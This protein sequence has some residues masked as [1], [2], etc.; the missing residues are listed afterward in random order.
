MV[1]DRLWLVDNGSCKTWDGD[2]NEYRAMLLD[3]QRS[4]ARSARSPTEDIPK[5]RKQVRQ[6]RAKARTE[7]ANLRKA[8]QEAEK[9]VEKLQ[10]KKADIEVRLT[11]PEVYEGPTQILQD[12]QIKVGKVKSD[13]AN[14]EDNWL[15]AQAKLEKTKTDYQ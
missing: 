10:Q 5:S 3:K 1:C 15:K 6:E 11:N 8:A 7:T 2:L 4:N 12:L 9:L 14:A 13:L